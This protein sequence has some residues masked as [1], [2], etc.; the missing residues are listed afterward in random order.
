MNKTLLFV[1]LISGLCLG[2]KYEGMDFYDNGSPKSFQ[3]FKELNGKLEPVKLVFWDENGQK[4]E[5]EI[6]ENGKLIKETE[7]YENGQKR[8]EEIYENGKRIKETEWYESGQKASESTRNG[9][10]VKILFWYSNGQLG[11]DVIKNENG[12]IIGNCWDRNGDDC[13]CEVGLGEACES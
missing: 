7:W 11:A 5:E 6:Y 12:D 9:E 2:Q 4:R 1:L 3:S 13:I 10:K 8:E